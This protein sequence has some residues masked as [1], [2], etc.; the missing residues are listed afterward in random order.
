M[1]PETI[2]QNKTNLVRMLAG[3][4][5]TMRYGEAD[6]KSG[7]AEKGEGERGMARV[8]AHREEGNN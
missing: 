2:G 3:D 7:R 5:K 6:R 8:R 1:W 4:Q